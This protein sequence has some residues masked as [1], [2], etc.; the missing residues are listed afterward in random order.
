L[1]AE[2]LRQ[3]ILSSCT[4]DEVLAWVQEH[5]KPTIDLDKK[6]WAEQIDRY[7]PDAA[8][9]EYRKRVYPELA[10]QVEVGSLSVLDLIDMDEGRL[11]I[12]R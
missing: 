10:A 3:V 8:L 5:A 7:R 6:T 11:P 9:V 2:A 12:K 4:D 1:N